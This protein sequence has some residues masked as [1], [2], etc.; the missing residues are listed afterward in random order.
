MGNILIN[1][2]VT[3]PTLWYMKNEYRIVCDEIPSDT[4]TDAGGSSGT[5]F[6]YLTEA[7]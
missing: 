7:T 4:T 1:L 2:L 6:L 3:L 5:A